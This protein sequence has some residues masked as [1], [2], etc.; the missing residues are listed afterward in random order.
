[1]TMQLI[2]PVLIQRRLNELQDQDLYIHLEMTTGA[3]ASHM[4][5]SKHPSATFISNARLRYTTGSISEKAPFFR[6]G[7]KTE[8]GWVYSEGLTHYEDTEQARLILAG[9]D[10][11]GKLV[12]A[13]QLSK[14]PF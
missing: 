5:S 3:Y 4:D 7:L 1:M 9:H 13:L 10:A 11:Q 12:V 2:D 6:V 14:E 8:T